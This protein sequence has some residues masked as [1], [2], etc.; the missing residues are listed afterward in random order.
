MQGAHWQLLVFAPQFAGP[1][2][3]FSHLQAVFAQVAFFGFTVVS[4]VLIVWLINDAN[5][6]LLLPPGF[7]LIQ[8]D[9]IEFW[10]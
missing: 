10:V 8:E 2:A 4:I 6:A 7:I 1:Q 9:V 5:I 3:H